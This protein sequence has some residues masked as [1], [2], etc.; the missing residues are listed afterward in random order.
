MLRRHERLTLVA[1]LA[2]GT[3]LAPSTAAAG[4]RGILFREVRARVL[5]ST[6][7]EK[8]PHEYASLLGK[9]YLRGASGPGTAPVAAGAANEALVERENLFWQSISGSRNP[10]SFEAYLEQFPDGVFARL[11]KPDCGAGRGSG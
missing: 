5:E 3:W 7:G 2:L 10:A 4:D 8:R 1:L 11:A 6:G 9:H